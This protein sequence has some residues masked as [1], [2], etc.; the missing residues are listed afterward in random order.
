MF[1]SPDPFVYA[2]AAFGQGAL[3]ILLNNVMCNGFETQLTSCAYDSN[4]LSCS[5][6]EDAGIKCIRGEYDSK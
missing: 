6:S 3:P 2:S 1:Y 4:T 5:H